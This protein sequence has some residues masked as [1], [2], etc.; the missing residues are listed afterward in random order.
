MI[1][2]YFLGLPLI[3]IV[4]MIFAVGA[5]IG[6]FWLDLSRTAKIAL[7]VATALIFLGLIAEAFLQP[8]QASVKAEAKRLDYAL[9]TLS[10]GR[11][12][13]VAILPLALGQL[14]FAC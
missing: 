4:L 10:D 9:T 6:Y 1:G 8:H 12:H 2:I 14:R 11:D 13:G 3:V 7:E 5:S